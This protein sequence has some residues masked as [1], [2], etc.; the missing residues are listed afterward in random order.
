MTAYKFN[1]NTFNAV[2]PNINK[3]TVGDV[4]YN[5]NA[6]QKDRIYYLILERDGYL[7]TL[8]SIENLRLSKAHLANIVWA[9]VKSM[10]IMVTE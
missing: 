5:P 7:L 9:K 6:P 4:I 8:L 10:E 1:V 2:E 3:F